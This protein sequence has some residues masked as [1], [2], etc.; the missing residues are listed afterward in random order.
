MIA[1]RNFSG[2]MTVHA[3]GSWVCEKP[4]K[5]KVERHPDPVRN[6]CSYKCQTLA[7]LLF[8]C[9]FITWHKLDF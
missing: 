2:I 9:C 7:A 6:R 5:H 1:V 8:E 4:D 3:D